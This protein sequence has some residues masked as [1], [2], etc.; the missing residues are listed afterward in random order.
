MRGMCDLS[1]QSKMSEKY[2]SVYLLPDHAAARL[3]INKIRRFLSCKEKYQSSKVL[4]QGSANTSVIVKLIFF[5][6]IEKI[7]NPRQ[8]TGSAQWS[9]I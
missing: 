9:P 2:E 7:Q 6:G 4:W 8:I 3:V 1:G 5:K